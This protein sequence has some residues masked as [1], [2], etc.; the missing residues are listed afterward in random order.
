MSFNEKILEMNQNIFDLISTKEL[1]LL[2]DL[3]SRINIIKKGEFKYYKSFSFDIEDVR[4][5]LHVLDSDRIY[6]LIPF[7]S[8]NN[9]INESHTILSQQILITSKSNP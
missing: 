1:T 5:F 7:I 2:K 3:D 6:T 4:N 9:K 8:I